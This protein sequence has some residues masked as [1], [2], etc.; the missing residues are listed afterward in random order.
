MTIGPLVVC[1]AGEGNVDGSCLYRLRDVPGC[2]G[3]LR[4]VRGDGLFF[5]EDAGSPVDEVL[6][7]DDSE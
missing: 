5:F 3:S 7:S 2:S 4:I 1:S 6:G